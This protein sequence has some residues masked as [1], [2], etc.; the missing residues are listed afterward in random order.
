M[1]E[2]KQVLMQKIHQ[3]EREASER[4]G[5]EKRL[6]DMEEIIGKM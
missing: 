6:K 4:A 5:S 3:Y 2:E 1:R